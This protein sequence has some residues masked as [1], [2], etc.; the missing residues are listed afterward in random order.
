MIMLS[1]F[2]STAYTWV[3]LPLLIFFTR[4]IDV[5]LGTLRIIFINRSLSFY[6]T[7]SAFFEVLVW[8]LVLREVF[9]RLD[10]PLCFIAYAA[11]YAAG[12]YVGIIIENM[13][14]IGKVIVRIITRKQADELVDY[15]RSAGY[16]ITAIDAEGTKGPV[17][18]I[19]SIVERKNLKS[20]VEIIKK[21]NPHSF[22][23]VEDVRFVSE[24]VTPYR[25]PAPRRWTNFY[26]RM[27]KK[28]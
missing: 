6:A 14:S 20:I 2:E 16:G 24:P 9:Q 7:I 10:N 8:L 15:L 12:N 13:V 26:S 1:F 27:R 18:T 11:G 17:K 23:S 25:L 3:V 19:F 21:F 5:S 28:V 22:Y 4:I